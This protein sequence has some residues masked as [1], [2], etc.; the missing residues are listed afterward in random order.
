LN[1]TQPSLRARLDTFFESNP[2]EM[3]AAKDVALKF[4][5]SLR[6][7]RNALSIL[8]NEGALERVTCWRVNRSCDHAPNP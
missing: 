2:T 4:N 3:L 6:Y 7:A 1:V 5:V 8:K